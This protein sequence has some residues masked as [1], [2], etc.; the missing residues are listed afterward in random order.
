MS[1]FKSR[2]LLLVMALGLALVLLAIIVLRYR[3]QSPLQRMERTLPK[4]VDVSLQDIDYTHVEEGHARWRLVARQVE[5]RAESGS[6]NVDSPQMDFYD[7]QGG[8]KGSL[9]ADRGIISDDYQKVGLRGDVIL[10]NSAGYTLFTDSLDY[11]QSTQTATSDATV[12][13]VS[14]GL[15]VEGS[16][17]VLYPHQDRFFLNADVK[18][19]F[20]T[21][22]MK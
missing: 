14:E 19:S 21:A 2:N 18:A 10:K 9:Q 7:M 22:K 17:L 12:R 5:R 16:G 3:P 4:G 11:D 15:H 8:S 1:Y 13:L 6:L 20:D